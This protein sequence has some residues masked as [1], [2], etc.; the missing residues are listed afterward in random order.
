[1]LEFKLLIKI[2]DGI[3]FI[4]FLHR[5]V[6]TYNLVHCSAYKFAVEFFLSYEH[7]QMSL[8]KRN[9]IFLHLYYFIYIVLHIHITGILF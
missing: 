4:F 1:M 5:A 6:F 8:V 7:W 9:A 3:V 2:A